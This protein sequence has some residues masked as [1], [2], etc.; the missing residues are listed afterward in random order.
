M[1]SI[2]EKKYDLSKLAALIAEVKIPHPSDPEGV[3]FSG[4]EIDNVQAVLE[5]CVQFHKEVAEGDRR[6]LVWNAIVA[7]AKNTRL[8]ANAVKRGIHHAESEYLKKPREE[9][10]LATTLSVHGLSQRFQRRVSN[11]NLTFSRT[12]P[13]RFARDSTKAKIDRTLKIDY[14]VNFLSARARLTA[15]TDSAALDQGLFAVDLMRSIWNFILNERIIARHSFGMNRES[16]NQIR[17]G[18]IHTLHRISGELATDTFWFD[19]DLPIIPPTRDLGKTWPDIQRAEHRIR[20]RLQRSPY[21]SDL[22][23]LLVKYGQALDHRDYE[24]AFNKLW[25]VL[26]HLTCTVGSNYATLVSRTSF[27]AADHHYAKLILEHLRDVRNRIVHHS[28][29]P[30]GVESYLHQLKPFVEG[31][32]RFHLAFGPRLGSLGSAAEFLDSPKD[33]ATLQRRIDLYDLALRYRRPE[34]ET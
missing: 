9:Y 5:S 19:S 7:A 32:F 33:P 28:V 20:A 11:V 31:L 23:G 21:S 17:L 4:F 29:S 26:E 22:E 27:I 30:A 6:R 16:V 10:V 18:P 24:V 13:R 14:P 15:R 12:L 1:A 2:D 34:P 3:A 8:D 25:S